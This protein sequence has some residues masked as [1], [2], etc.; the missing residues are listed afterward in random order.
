MN[1]GTTKKCLPGLGARVRE[2]RARQGKNRQEGEMSVLRKD[3]QD[4]LT[5]GPTETVTFAFT[6]PMIDLAVASS[7]PGALVRPAPHLLHAAR[8]T[9]CARTLPGTPARP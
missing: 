9:R 1:N 4:P 6:R 3:E 5:D 7:A 2:L 8:G